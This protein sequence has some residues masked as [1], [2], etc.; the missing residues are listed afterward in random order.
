MRSVINPKNSRITW[1]FTPSRRWM[2]PSH[3]DH[4]DFD[5]VSATPRPSRASMSKLDLK[6]KSRHAVAELSHHD[7]GRLAIPSYAIQN[8]FQ[9]D[10]SLFKRIVEPGTVMSRAGSIN[11]LRSSSV[12]TRSW[13]SWSES[14]FSTAPAVAF[15]EEIM[16][17]CLW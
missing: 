13:S 3:A 6:N 1:N 4:H 17:D 9:V 7:P 12:V 2:C 14:E 5:R 11:P 16:W 10:L 15:F 8:L